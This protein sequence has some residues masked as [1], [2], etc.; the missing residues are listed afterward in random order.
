[1]G[2]EDEWCLGEEEEWG[3]SREGDGELAELSR[4]MSSGSSKRGSN[5]G[6]WVGET[7]GLALG[8]QGFGPGLFQGELAL[9]ACWKETHSMSVAARF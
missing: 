9:L 2:E 6:R 8:L 7:L 1:M 4:A 3:G 5:P